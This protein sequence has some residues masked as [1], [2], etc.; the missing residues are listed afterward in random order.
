MT[1]KELLSKAKEFALDLVQ[2]VL[3]AAFCGSV[4]F[5]SAYVGYS[6]GNQNASVETYLEV[7]DY[8]NGLQTSKICQG[9]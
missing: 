4:M 1:N 9:T 2:L 5:G 3:I 8:F 7:M 6:I